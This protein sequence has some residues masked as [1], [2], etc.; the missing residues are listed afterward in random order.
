MSRTCAICHEGRKIS[1]TKV[2]RAVEENLFDFEMTLKEYGLDESPYAHPQCLLRYRVQFAKE[3]TARAM[4][5]E[6]YRKFHL[7]RK[8]A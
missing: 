2:G 4:T 8:A 7:K 6:Q 1:S 3:A 5:L